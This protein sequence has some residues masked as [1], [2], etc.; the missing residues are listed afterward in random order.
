MMHLEDCQIAYRDISTG[1]P[2]VLIMGVGG[3]M[4]EWD[5]EFLEL[6]ASQY[7][8]IIFDNRGIGDSASEDGNCS[9]STIAEDTFQLIRGIGIKEAHILGYSMGSMVALDLNENHPEIASSLILYATAMNGKETADRISPYVD[10]ATP[11]VISVHALFPEKWIASHPDLMTIFPPPSHPINGPAILRQI[12]D[13]KYW[14]TDY[15]TLSSINIPV[16]IIVGSEDV[17]TPPDAVAEVANAISGSKMMKIPGGGHGVLYQQPEKMARCIL[18]FL[19]DKVPEN[20]GFLKR[21]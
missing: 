2:L 4:S 13:T 19:S 14:K 7:R 21:L 12:K 5:R 16:F 10:I 11:E 15:E 20:S 18:D 9:I 17:I 8:L 3:T 6:L 1:Y